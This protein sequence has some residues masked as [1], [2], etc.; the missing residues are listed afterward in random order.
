MKLKSITFKGN[1]FV[2]CL[3]KSLD[4]TFSGDCEEFGSWVIIHLQN[5]KI[6]AD[7]KGGSKV[8]TT[9]HNVLIWGGNVASAEIAEA[10]N[11]FS[12]PLSDI[13]GEK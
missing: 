8:E 13:L 2:P 12:D 6:V 5:Q 3:G 4:G 1:V 11:V 10:A 9:E 7:G